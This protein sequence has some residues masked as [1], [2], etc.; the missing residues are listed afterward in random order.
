M[1]VVIGGATGFLGRTLARE[2]AE[3]GHEVVVLTR[4]NQA[5]PSARSVAWDGSTV[6]E[7][8]RELEGSDVVVNFSGA[9]ITLKWTDENK[10]KIADSRL[11][12]TKAIREAIDACSRPPKAFLAGSAIGYY[13][14]TG[15]REVDESS[16][17]GIGFMADLCEEWEKASE[18]QST[19]VVRLRTGIVLGKESGMLPTLLKLTKAFI[20]GQVGDG[21]Q[22]VPWIHIEDYVRLVRWCGLG[23]VSGPVNLCAPRPVTNA[24]L[25]STLRKALNRPWAPPAPAFAVKALGFVGPDPSLALMSTRAVPKVA[26]GKGFAY[27]WPE[28]DAALQNLLST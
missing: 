26:T 2:C 7:W 15:E 24:E 20:G 10:K 21:R 25:M 9:P 3:D 14:D 4:G 16:E 13:G 8:A 27:K 17:K 6:G 22:Y 18:T 28:L 12:P 1:K 23:N 5:V 11:L 19:R